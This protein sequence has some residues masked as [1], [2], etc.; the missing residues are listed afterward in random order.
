LSNEIRNHGSHEPNHH[1]HHTFRRQANYDEKGVLHHH[2]DLKIPSPLLVAILDARLLGEP[3]Q[4]TILR[5]LM[6]GL[7]IG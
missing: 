4:E 2:I 3:L 6:E 1:H 7:K 5:L